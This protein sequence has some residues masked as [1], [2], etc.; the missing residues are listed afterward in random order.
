[1][2][3][4]NLLNNKQLCFEDEKEAFTVGSVIIK[5]KQKIQVIKPSKEPGNNW[6]IELGMTNPRP[7]EQSLRQRWTKSSQTFLWRNPFQAHQRKTHVSTLQVLLFNLLVAV[8]ATLLSCCC[9]G[10]SMQRYHTGRDSGGAGRV[11][12]RAS[13]WALHHCPAGRCELVLPAPPLRHRCCSSPAGDGQTMRNQYLLEQ[14]TK[15]QLFSL[16]QQWI[17]K[18]MYGESSKN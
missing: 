4:S 5:S 7:L 6:A 18:L 15:A 17:P 8:S 10:P 9:L 3:G 14:L 13:H 11:C 16:S 1:M 12:T 2:D